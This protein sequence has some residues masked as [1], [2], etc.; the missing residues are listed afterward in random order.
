MNPISGPLT[1]VAAGDRNELYHYG[2]RLEVELDITHGGVK[3]FVGHFYVDPE[4]RGNDI[5]PTV[6]QAIIDA[7]GERG[8]QTLEIH[9]QWTLDEDDR[10][11]RERDPSEELLDEFG[12]DYT[13]EPSSTN[14]SDEMLVGFRGL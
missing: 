12:F 1:A 11:E 8:C 4:F 9:I 10:A 13:P 2:D 7:A 6:L 3:A 14:D 5:G